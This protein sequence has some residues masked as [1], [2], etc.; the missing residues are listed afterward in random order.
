MSGSGLN[1][2]PDDGICELYDYE[3]LLHGRTAI[4]LWDPTTGDKPP[5]VVRTHPDTRV[6]LPDYVAHGG[7]SVQ[8]D[9]WYVS[10]LGD[11][12]VAFYPLGTTRKTSG[13]KSRQGPQL[14]LDGRSGGIV[15]MA[16]VSEFDSLD[17]YAADMA[18]RQLSFTK[19]PL[20][21][22]FEARDPDTGKLVTVRLE[23]RPERRVIGGVEQ[24]IEQALGHGLM[25]SPWVS[26]DPAQRQLRL[27]RECY[28][29]TIYD[30]D[31]GV[32]TDLPPPADC[33][34]VG[35]LGG[36]PKK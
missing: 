21:A 3:R 10:R 1:E 4:S 28:P 12:Y 24:T 25:K 17:G 20:A 33:G 29:I 26:W 7:E 34:G 36:G 11:V 15:E 9:G 5:G 18:S 30:W 16:T 2:D 32:V 14:V 6:F 22:E 31:D 35:A 19:T 8:V 27:E 13:K 23:H